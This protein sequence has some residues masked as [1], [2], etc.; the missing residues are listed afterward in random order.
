MLMFI[1]WVAS[2][3]IAVTLI[4]VLDLHMPWS[5]VLGVGAGAAGVLLGVAAER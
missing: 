4:I 2:M 5:A 1:G 3:C